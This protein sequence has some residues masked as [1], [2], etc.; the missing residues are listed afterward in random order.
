MTLSGKTTLAKRRAF[1]FRRAGVP[2][3][4]CDPTSDPG[5]PADFVTRDQA[6][7]LRAYWAS[8][9]CAAFFD[10]GSRSVGKYNLETEDTATLGRHRGHINHYIVQRVTQIPPIVRDQ[11]TEIFLFRSSRK[12][13]EMLADEWAIDELALCAEL[14]MLHYIHAKRDGTWQRKSL[15]IGGSN[16]HTNSGNRT[17][18]SSGGSNHGTAESER[19]D[20]GESIS[21][22]EE[23]STEREGNDTE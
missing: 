16:E 3:L 15:L 23:G 5:W 17:R 4:V 21:G 13:G 20:S 7:F 12:D 10:E 2:V 14:P 22:S 19:T 9:S 11:C 6:K 1:F 18:N 8:T